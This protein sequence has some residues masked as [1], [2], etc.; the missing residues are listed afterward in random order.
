MTN[1]VHVACVTFVPELVR[2]LR[3]CEDD[4][5]CSL[6]GPAADEI[7]RLR[8]RLEIG[9]AFD[10]KGE[11]IA[12]EETEAYDGIVC[13][14]ATIKLQDEMLAELRKGISEA[15][16]SWIRCDARM[17]EDAQDVLLVD[18]RGNQCVGSW[19]FREGRWSWAVPAGALYVE[20]S[21]W[22]ALPEAP[23]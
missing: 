11:R 19:L 18:Y 5:D 22:M 16:P 1:P 4:D 20:P 2:R 7:M 23:K 21:H 12:C 10:S 14:D 17:P 13:R 8:E 3:E 9:Y 15:S 6:C